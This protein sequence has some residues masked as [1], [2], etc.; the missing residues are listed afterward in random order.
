MEF[1][2][3]PEAFD[4]ISVVKTVKV[5]LNLYEDSTE[6]DLQ[7]SHWKMHAFSIYGNNADLNYPYL[8][9]RL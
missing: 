6:I 5:E 2:S 1:K 8:L 4:E 9:F 7:A 3:Y